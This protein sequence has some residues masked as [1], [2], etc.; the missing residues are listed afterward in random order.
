M[1]AAVFSALL[2]L[3]YLAPTLYMLQVYDRVVPTRGKLTLGFITLV[4]LL[5]VGTLSL[6]DAVRSRLMVRA[7]IRLDRQLA[8]AI[9]DATLARPIAGRDVL[10]KQAMREFDTL[11]QAL[12]GTAMLALFD[13]PWTPF[14]ILICFLLH[15]ALGAV[16]LF[17]AIILGGIAWLNERATR[18]RLQRANEAS[19]IAYVSQEQSAAGAEVVRALGMRGAMVRRHLHERETSAQLQAEA[20]FAGGGFLAATRFVRLSLQSVA[21]GVGAWLAIEQKISA[22]AIFAAS[23]LVARALAPVEQLLGA[24]R[25]V[26]Q[27][28]G[29]WRTLNE[30]LERASPDLAITQLPA[31]TGQIEA[32]RLTVLT[33]ARDAAILQQISFNAAAGEIIGVIGPSGA[34]K[35]TLMR[36]LSGASTP[37][38][39]AIR[40][41]GAEMR[42]Y[43]PERLARHIGYMPQDASL[44]AGTVKENIARFRNHLGEDPVAIDEMAIEAAA[45]CGAHDMILRLADGYDTILGWGGRGLSAGQ[46]QRI[47]LAR[48]LFGQ[49]SL[50]LLDEPNAHL[51][52]EG[53]AQLVNT[54]KA[55]KARGATVMIVAHRTGVLAAIDKLMVL[56]EGRLELY[57]E[58]DEVIGRLNAAA[59]GQPPLPPGGRPE[60][61]APSSSEAPTS[62][63]APPSVKAPQ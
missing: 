54:L 21:L 14:Y 1:G 26:T 19:N 9:L 38:A 13:A 57:G 22:G 37:D 24:W 20:S 58:R 32:E 29:A 42:D 61:K 51:D 50:L 4:L 41:D 7:S 62:A 47:A 60:I 36:M 48:A 39:G 44:F 46:A 28:R 43:D 12:T 10:T 16:V 52:M 27:A 23:F 53:E 33:P 49:P 59:R 55:L 34:G 45:F 3:L 30:T 31:P 11:R 15:P 8:G 5:A 35:S 63:E 18:S 56:R 25:S 17:G 40:F 6:L 2:N